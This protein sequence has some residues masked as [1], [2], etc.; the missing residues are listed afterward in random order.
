M[1]EPRLSRPV[2]RAPGVYVLLLEVRGR[3][4]VE[5]RTLRAVIEPGLYAYVGSA[6]GPGGLRAR[7]LRHLKRR[8][9]VWWHIDRLTTS[10]NA[11]VLAAAYC[12]TDS[13]GPPAEAGIAL[14][15]SRRGYQ[16]VKR[17][18][19]TDDPQAESHL[20]RAPPTEGLEGALA[21]SLECLGDAA[22]SGKCGTSLYE[23]GSRSQP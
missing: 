21:D 10:P 4:V 12:I 9:R 1:A 7:I 22:G 16:P 15:L 18:G 5:A 23:G 8:K 17:F 19:S 3:V 11:G 6:C 2:P 14:C 20:Y 13:C